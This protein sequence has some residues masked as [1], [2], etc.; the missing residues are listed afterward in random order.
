ML[1][2][3]AKN[4]SLL[5]VS[6]GFSRGIGFFYAVFL[7]RFWGVELFG[8]YIFALT[9]VYSLLPLAD[10]GLERFVLRE[11]SRFPEKTSFY[12][13]RLFS[14]RLCLSLGAYFL[15]LIL[16]FFLSRTP[17]GFLAVLCLGIFLLPY[18]LVY[19]MC[20]FENA[21]ERMETMALA[22]VGTIGLTALLGL[23]FAMLGLPFE[24]VL[25][26]YFW[27][28]LLILLFCLWRARKTEIN[29]RIVIDWSFFRE[30]VKQSWSFALL[31]ILSVFYLRLSVLMVGVLKTPYLTGL[32]GGAFKFIEALILIP[33]SFA[34]A[35]FPLSSRLFQEDRKTL[36][37]VYLKAVFYS[38]LC[39]LPL[40]AAL[41][42]FSS[43]I[44]PLT[45]G[46]AY[47]PTIS[48]LS[49][50]GLSLFFFF[51]NALVGNVVLNSRY[52]NR[53]IPVVLFYFI[54]ELAACLFF[55]P[56]YGI[57]GA[58]AAVLLG[59]IFGFIVNNLFI[60]WIFTREK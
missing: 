47:L 35:L 30:I 10:F 58:A 2:K 45:Y 4:T 3:V 5:F 40:A 20:S 19:L 18:N 38:F 17:A 50:L 54:F 29:F 26:S 13:S 51:P 59:E 60:W 7:A 28:S 34:L 48:P 37:A 33:Q 46:K 8:L 56:R 21:K 24:I 6:Q 53:F 23:I 49:I 31:T 25:L 16:G 9:L 41:F 57:L 12:F 22:N 15:L 27:G 39:S 36:K 52:V 11:I 42:L 43:S 1:K 55:I 14:L 44:V 32:Y